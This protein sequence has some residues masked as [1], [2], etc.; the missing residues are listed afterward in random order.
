V[1]RLKR[2]NPHSHEHVAAVRRVVQ[3]AVF[4]CL[5]ATASAGAAQTPDPLWTDGGVGRFGPDDP[6]TFGAFRELAR[7]VSPAV[8]HIRVVV[9]I[10]GPSLV[11]GQGRAE[12]EG[13]GFIIHQDGYIVTNNHVIENA[14]EIVVQLADSRQVPAVVVGTDPRTDLALIRVLV[15]YPLP[16]ARLGDSASLEVGDWVVAIG[17]PFGL[18]MTV[19][20]GIVS[21]LGRRDIRPQNRD[22]LTNFIQTDA[23]INPGNSGGPLVDINGHVVGVNTAVNR[24]ANNIGFAIPIDMVKALL[25]QLATGSVERAWLGVRLDDLRGDDVAAYGLTR[26]NAARVSEVIPGS[27]AAAAGLRVGDVILEFGGERIDEFRELPW[28]ASVAGIGS[29]VPVLVLRDDARLTLDVT[30]GRLPGTNPATGGITDPASGRIHGLTV[31]D[32][33]ADLASELNVADGAGVVVLGVSSP[34]PA[35]RAGLERGDVIVRIGDEE[36]SSAAALVESLRDLGD[37]E[38]IQLQVRRGRA[39]VFVFFSTE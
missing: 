31:S 1:V 32:L 27:P 10:P 23:S 38:S 17:N 5:V 6:V 36:V 13:T 18:E 33:S 4:V 39:T 25:P 9:R 2:T 34:S 35:E 28:L 22:M 16:I 21:A 30:M 7:D 19:T 20:A 29:V 3:L 12:G 37:A 11:P 8:V 26:A 15:D 24:A 14:S